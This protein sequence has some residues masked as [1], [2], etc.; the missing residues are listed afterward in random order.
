MAPRTPS[1]STL[2]AFV[3]ELA[4]LELDK[5]QM[6]YSGAHR[7]DFHLCSVNTQHCAAHGATLIPNSL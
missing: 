3:P 7:M 2:R 4:H 5:L 1:L 6:A